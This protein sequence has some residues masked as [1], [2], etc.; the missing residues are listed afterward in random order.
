MNKMKV[1]KQ[2]SVDLKT[3]LKLPQELLILLGDDEGNPAKIHKVTAL[4]MFETMPQS[5]CAVAYEIM[6]PRVTNDFMHLVVVYSVTANQVLR[7]LSA[8]SEVTS[9]CTPADDT[10]LIVGTSVGSIC[11]F[12]MSDFEL[13]TVPFEFLNYRALL[14]SKNPSALE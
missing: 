7:I 8:E 3:K 6:S 11:L 9:M 1:A 13:A 12:D 2:S 5:K 14:A 4:H 10:I